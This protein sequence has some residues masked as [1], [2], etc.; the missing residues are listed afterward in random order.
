MQRGVLRDDAFVDA[1]DPVRRHDVVLCTALQP[2]SYR[3]QLVWSVQRLCRD[4]VKNAL[5]IIW[6]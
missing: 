5:V 4:P 2:P 1:G 3:V 6:P